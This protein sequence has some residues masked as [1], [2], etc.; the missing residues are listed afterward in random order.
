MKDNEPK[1]NQTERFI[2]LTEEIVKQL[3]NT[4]TEF[5]GIV[6]TITRK[7]LEGGTRALYLGSD[8]K[9]SGRTQMMGYPLSD[10]D[11][12]ISEYASINDRDYQNLEQSK[13]WTASE[14]KR[15]NYIQKNKKRLFNGLLTEM[16][17]TLQRLQTKN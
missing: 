3:Q 5:K 13:D 1:L 14:T 9:W 15:Q 7:D 17:S 16:E 4:P 12:V 6:T 2:S 10:T 11:S 8:G